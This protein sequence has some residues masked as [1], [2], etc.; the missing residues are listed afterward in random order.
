ML[1]NKTLLLRAKNLAEQL[2]NIAPSARGKKGISVKIA[3]VLEASTLKQLADAFTALLSDEEIRSRKD[4]DADVLQTV[5]AETLSLPASKVPL[6]LT[7][8][9][10]E[11][12]VINYKKQ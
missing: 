2:N 8:L 1:D 6:F 3:Q 4:L 5:I 9:R 7:L 11:S 12:S 10:F